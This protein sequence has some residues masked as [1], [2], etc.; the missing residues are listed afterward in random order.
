MK[1]ILTAVFI[2]LLCVCL[3]ACGS[4]SINTKSESD[5]PSARHSLLGDGDADNPRDIDGDEHPDNDHDDDSRTSEGYGYHDK[6]DSLVLGFGHP[7]TAASLQ[8]ITAFVKRYYAAA[9]TSDG[10]TACS[11]LPSSVAHAVPEDYGQA[12][13]PIYTRGGKTCSAVMSMLFKH[14]HDQLAA[15]I[16]VTGVR[17][18]GNQAEALIGSTTMLASDIMLRRE[19][20]NWKV[21]AL[22]SSTIP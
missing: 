14:F 21:L 17:V 3:A 6:D 18:K 12:P 7:A 5:A 11:L 15:P 13:G 8:A 22:L 19:G 16:Q 2:T 10:A 4:S 20:S 9:A 1:R